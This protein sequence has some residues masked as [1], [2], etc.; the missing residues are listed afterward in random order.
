M[1]KTP[2]MLLPPDSAPWGR[3]ITK[4]VDGLEYQTSKLDQDITNSLKGLNA[5]V[6]R[7][8]D[9]IQDLNT[10]ATNLAE[11]QAALSDQQGYLSSLISRDATLP[12]FNTG[13]LINDSTLRFTGGQAVI[14]NMPVATG[15]VRV[16]ISTSEASI[17]SG[18]NFVIGSIS[19]GVD[20]VLP[21]DPNDRLA[22]LYAPGISFGASLTRVG[23][24]S[25]APGTYTFRAQASYWSSGA[26]TASINFAG[27]RL[28]VE[29]INND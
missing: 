17:S 4:R 19:F 2:D 18:G 5:A 10:I 1:S 20:G 13:T 12:G 15:K 25:L 6:K 22:R 8:G 7:I 11:Q 16:T 23:T 14:E 29:V 3:D 26:G 24:V 27:L 28:L 9:Q 21:L